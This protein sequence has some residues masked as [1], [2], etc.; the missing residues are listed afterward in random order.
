M[1]ANGC[2]D[3]NSMQGAAVELFQIASLLMGNSAEA[4][5]LVEETVAAIVVDPCLDPV[6]ARASAHRQMMALALDR[7]RES[8]PESFNTP[9]EVAGAGAVCVEDEDLDGSSMAQGQLAQWMATEGRRD[10]RTWLAAM[11]AAHRVI[12]VQRAVLGAGNEATARS[13]DV[14]VPIKPIW[15]PAAVRDV[16]R[17]ALC[18]LANS[19]AHAPGVIAEMASEPSVAARA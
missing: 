18:S 17:M 15:T 8:D 16:Y 5:S 2:G 9:P 7:L 13:L 4:V 19:L 1:S 6:A 3:A 10:L 14:Q 12:F 11:P